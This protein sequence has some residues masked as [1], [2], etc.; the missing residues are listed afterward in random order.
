MGAI[1]GT[2]LYDACIRA[3]SFTHIVYNFILLY[4]VRAFTASFTILTLYVYQN[5]LFPNDFA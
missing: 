5:H 1:F 3:N 4:R 2:F